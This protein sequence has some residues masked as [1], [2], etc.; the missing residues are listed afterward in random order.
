V[1]DI[2]VDILIIEE[3]REAHIA[4][5]NVTIDEVLEVLIG[6]YVFIAGR[7]ERWL[8]IGQT[9]TKRYL[10]VVVGQRPEPHTFGLV[11]ARPSRRKERSF[12][13]GFVTHKG[14][15]EA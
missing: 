3:G 13:A 9:E 4:K 6:D 8:L 15:D 11:T 10:T 12:Y 14:G 2:I 5:H 1:K 7:D